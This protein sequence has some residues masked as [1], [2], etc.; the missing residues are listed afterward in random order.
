MSKLLGNLNQL[1]LVSNRLLDR[2]R[3]I[4]E[5]A[6][7]HSFVS[8]NRLKEMQSLAFQLVHKIKDMQS[9]EFE[10]EVHRQHYQSEDV[11]LGG[12]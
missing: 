6:G 5:P 3:T 9:V 12:S 2:L 11:D 1:D 4:E 8:S 7:D 10:K